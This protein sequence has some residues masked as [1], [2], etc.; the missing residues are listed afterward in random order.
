MHNILLSF[1]IPV[2]NVE[3]YVQECIDSITRQWNN[4]CEI[5]LVDDGSTDASGKICD[6][7][8]SD[9]IHVIH[10]PNGGLSS[11]RN[12]GLSFA[13]G[14][15]IA[16]VDSDDRI[17]DKSVSGIIEWIKKSGCDYCFMQALKFFPDGSKV[18]LGDN[19]KSLR[20]KS[21]DEVI[22]YISSR[23][24]Y[25]GGACTKIYKKEFLK[26][27]NIAFP[28]DRRLSEDLGFTRDCI[29]K[30]ESYDVL[31]FPYYE[32]RQNR[33]GSIT[34][35][36]GKESVLGIVAFISESIDLLTENRVPRDN[37]CKYAM[38][39]V[40]YEYAVLLF[41]YSNYKGVF[42]DEFYGYLCEYKW[43]LK[44]AVSKRIYFIRLIVSC[45]GLKLTSEALRIA[46][47][48]CK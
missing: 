29:L 4:N 31:P 12:V 23:P 36:V 42:L 15:Y 33:T 17:A 16:F 39:F 34:S 45:V 19:I 11:A 28:D 7:N 48:I 22:H 18:D 26:K 21:K 27:Y 40:A 5:I 1:I 47:C 37:I 6:L 46:K 13:V 30:A 3:A 43:T 41:L 44:F 20:G 25:P 9:R 14:E 24:K 8:Q 10:K 32:Y 35:V 38:S 2:Y